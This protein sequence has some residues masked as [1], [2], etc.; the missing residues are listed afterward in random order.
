[1]LKKQDQPLFNE[2]FVYQGDPN[3]FLPES[4]A[5][6]ESLYGLPLARVA[7]PPGNVY[8]PGPGEGSLRSCLTKPPPF[9]YPVPNLMKAGVGFLESTCGSHAAL[10]GPY[11]PGPTS[12][13]PGGTIVGLAALEN[14]GTIEPGFVESTC[15]PILCN[16]V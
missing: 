13:V 2:Q 6:G 15:F 4:V 16:G 1:M 12:D 3:L 8:D 11:S 10:N 14:P 5:D 7:T 9:L